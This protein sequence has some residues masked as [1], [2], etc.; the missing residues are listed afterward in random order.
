MTN[1]VP[2]LASMVLAFLLHVLV[3]YSF[4]NQDQ[5]EAKD[6]GELGIEVDLGML[7]ELGV[8]DLSTV[9][10]IAPAQPVD[11]P[12]LPEPI[13]EKHE[14]PEANAQPVLEDIVDVTNPIDS[15]ETTKVVA[16]TEPKTKAIATVPE[17]NMPI[18]T[19]QPTS[20]SKAITDVTVQSNQEHNQDITQTKRSTG[21]ADAMT[22]GG[23]KGQS[24]TYLSALA[25]HLI[26]HKRYPNRSRKNNEEGLVT[27]YFIVNKTGLISDL[28]I[29]KSSGYSRLDNAVLKMVRQAV[30][31]PQFPED[32]D[33]STLP[34]SIP[35][36]F[37]LEQV[38]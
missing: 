3:F 22:T 14:K 4:I 15:A 37:K 17:N 27:V 9:S 28:K 19:M 25:A 21:R 31:L 18:N 10:D 12:E 26:K 33:K 23:H 1:A 6:K 11:S 8:S 35:I 30:P 13:V 5:S 7:G 2:W 20:E 24:P 29:I 32:W 36:E 16:K 38:S 34:I